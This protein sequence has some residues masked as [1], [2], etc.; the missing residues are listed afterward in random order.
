MSRRTIVL[1][2]MAGAALLA[3][4]VG[5]LGELMNRWADTARRVTGRTPREIAGVV[6]GREP[7]RRLRHD[8]LNAE[9]VAGLAAQVVAG[10]M[11][12]RATW[13][14]WNLLAEAAR[15]TRRLRMTSTG[16]RLAVVDRVHAAALELCVRLDPDDPVSVPDELRRNDGASVFSRAGEQR[17]SHHE[18]LAAEERLLDAHTTLGGPVAAEATARRLAALPQPAR[19]GAGG[20]VARLAADQVDAVVTIATSG[21]LVDVLVGPA[22]TGKTTTLRALR[23]V[24]ESGHGRGSVIGLTPSANAAHQLAG[25]VGIGCETISKWLTE[26]TGPAAGHRAALLDELTRRRTRAAAAGD[27]VTVRRLDGARAV[28]QRAQALWRLRRGQLVIVDEASLAGTLGLDAL[29]AQAARAGAKVLL[30]GDHAQLSAVDAGGGF[31]LLARTGTPAELHS[32]WRFRHRWEAEATRRLRHGDPGVIDAYQAHGRLHGGPAETMTEQAYGA[33]LHDHRA[34]RSVILVA[35]DNHTVIALNQRVHTDRMAAGEVTGLT[36]PLGGPGCGPDRGRVGVGDTVLTRKNDRTL[37]ITGGDHVRN[38]ALWTV[39]AVHDDGSL[40]VQHSDWVGRRFVTVRLPA[41]YVAE[42]VDL[43]YAT[44]AHRAQGITVDCCHVLAAA[45]MPREAFYVAMTRGR[46]ANTAYVASDPIDPWCDGAGAGQDSPGMRDVLVG[47]LAD[48]R[49]ETSATEAR[50]QSADAGRSLNRLAPIRATIASVIDRRRWPTLLNEAG[51]S[52]SDIDAITASPAAG[53]LFAALRRGEALGH[54]MHRV[55]AQLRPS[56]IRE[57]IEDLA[58]VLHHR[59]ATWLATAPDLTGQHR[60]PATVLGLTEPR[61]DAAADPLGGM[62]AAVDALIDS[63][64]EQLVQELSRSRP[65]WFPP[66]TT[67]VHPANDPTRHLAVAA[68]HRDLNGGNPTN[69]AH[70]V[71]DRRRRRIAELAQRRAHNLINDRS[72]P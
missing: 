30:I 71:S 20:R 64:I 13:N 8:Q 5:G 2:S 24:W 53:P 17:Y 55:T 63:R 39:N 60:T 25:T 59:V 19:P 35:A 41:S 29:R 52:A 56:G 54:A 36:V 9:V 34:G 10:V 47:I 62:L 21:R 58:A 72:A 65:G 6:L 70:D 15:A 42:H 67:A 49:A 14:Q 50:E 51:F 28:L 16:D 44:T 61:H 4:W 1:A 31:G 11:E 46:Y 68:A 37:R 22:G 48:T 69:P 7:E 45:G 12:R 38:G 32:L 3:A 23:T 66:S 27:R 18:L 40:T 57:P 43:G 33:W 26:T